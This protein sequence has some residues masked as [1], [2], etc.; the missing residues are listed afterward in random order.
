MALKRS[1]IPLLGLLTWRPMSGYELKQEIEGSLENF[2]S[3]SFG[4]LYPHLHELHQSGLI[5][6][7]ETGVNDNRSKRTY[8]ITDE[9]RQSLRHWLSEAPTVRPLRNELLLKVFFAS[10]GDT[11]KILSHCRQARAEALG[12]L[13][14]YNMIDERLNGLAKEIAKARYWRMTLRFGI[15]QTKSL[16]SWC[17]TTIEELENEQTN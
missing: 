6:E 14:R 15:S 10:E 7:L 11:A 9:G 17:D 1:S 12:T 5:E 2:W 16:I 13:E 4:Q 3:E 8:A